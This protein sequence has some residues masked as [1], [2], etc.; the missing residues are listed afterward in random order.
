MKMLN[1]FEN[2]YQKQQLFS[3]ADAILLTV[4]G[5]KDSVVMAH[6]FH[7]SKL[8]FGIAHCNFK[9]RGKESDKDEKFVQ[10]LAKKLGVSFYS[11]SFN[12]AAFAIDKKISTQ[13][14]ARELRYQWFEE[15]TL[16]NN[17]QFIATAH[18]KNDVAETVLIN[19]TKG[20]GLRGLHGIAAKNG[21]I[22][23]PL[24][25]FNR[26][27]IDYFIEKNCLDFR[28]D[29]SNK[30][31][32]YVRNKI[33][34]KVIPELEKINPAFIETMFNETLLFAELEQLL[35]YKIDEDRKKC[36]KVLSQHTEIDI[37]Q[38]LSLQPIKTYLY[39][40]LKP[41]G[42]NFS[43]VEDVSQSL[44][45]QSG[46]TFLSGTHQIIKDRKK[47]IISEFASDNNSEIV[48]NSINDFKILPI[49]INAKIVNNEVLG[50]LKKDKKIAYFNADKISYPMVLRR[51]EKGD[52][53]KPFGM[54]NTKKLSDFFID[55]KL[56]LKEK[57][58]VWLLTQNNQIIWVV[59]YRINDDFKITSTTKNVLLLEI[60]K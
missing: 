9:L 53:F 42:F 16:K 33:R 56:S 49:K 26:Q 31:T 34:H 12:T 7:A 11:K 4:S 41:F 59:G 30:E 57:E 25:C 52:R 27:E 43:D 21:K 51:W 40:F 48:I 28:E 3:K 6:L 2:F 32:K 58:G 13:M 37:E 47:L 20:T 39:Y 35:E 55:E 10:N 50:S 19:L 22:V 24:L 45:K 54:K 17:Y 5:G 29:L 38:L 1:K 44:N 14:A 18:H 36:V 46:K 15:L 60:K 23:R 8:N